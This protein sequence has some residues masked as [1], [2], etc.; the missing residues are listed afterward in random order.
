MSPF[1]RAIGVGAG[2]VIVLGGLKLAGEVLSPIIFA[3]WLAILCLPIVRSLERKGWP[4][5]AWMLLLIVAVVGLFVALGAFVFLTIGQVRR[6]LPEYL[7]QV[8]MLAAQLQT[9]L[10]RFDID[11]SNINGDMLD[12]GTVLR[13]ATNVLGQTINGVIFGLLL[14]VGV[15]F[16]ILESDRIGVKLR[17]GLGSDSPLVRQLTQFSDSMQQFFYLRTINN[18]I[19]AVGAGV[20]LVILR[21]DF[22]VAWAV[23]IFFLSY[24][25]NIGI[26]LACIPA[27]V[28]AL[29]QHGPVTA[30]IVVVGLTAINYIGDWALTP[31]LMSQGLGLSQLT[32]FLSFFFWAYIF[33][34]V[35]GLLSV[36]LTLL[37]KLLLEISD[38]TRWLA[39]L[40]GDKAPRPADVAGSTSEALHETAVMRSDGQS[41][42]AG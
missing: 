19:V 12:P 39:V 14:V 25:P 2:I 1:V 36:P 23:L 41:D 4:R 29:L 8:N 35:G 33:G 37:V 34:A 42:Q 11:L 6:R 24:I 9:V 40:M 17:Y 32:V 22:A 28:L 26:I 38:S 13:T 10:D 20:F 15:I 7:V 30:V 21:I 31:R 3:T 18:L 16:M 5:W 27:V